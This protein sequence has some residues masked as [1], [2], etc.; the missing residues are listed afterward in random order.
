MTASA[1][2]D[3][4]PAVMMELASSTGENWMDATAETMYSIRRRRMR[5][6]SSCSWWLYGVSVPSQRHGHSCMCMLTRSPGSRSSSSSS[7]P[8]FL[9]KSFAS[10]SASSS[11]SSSASAAPLVFVFG[12]D[13]ELPDSVAALAFDSA[14]CFPLADFGSAVPFL[15]LARFFSSVALSLAI[16]RLICL[17]R[18]SS[19]CFAAAMSP[20][21]LAALGFGT[22]RTVVKS[23][24]MRANCRNLRFLMQ[25]CWCSRR[26][27][28]LSAIRSASKASGRT[29]I[30]CG[31]WRKSTGTYGASLFGYPRS[32]RF[33]GSS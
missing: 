22:G 21:S 5:R 30:F 28:K 19:A 15:A 4:H 6:I 16:R 8:F 13:R 32:G 10:A 23:A 7:M 3:M 9:G 24:S 1:M 2:A 11:S 20:P 29:L 27:H 14:A 31:I 18:R 26:A 33:S 17:C 25:W 12:S